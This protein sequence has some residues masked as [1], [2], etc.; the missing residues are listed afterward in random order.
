MLTGN[1]PYI[2]LVP[3]KLLS[4]WKR[5][6][7]PTL[8]VEASALFVVPLVSLWYRWEVRT[9]TMKRVAHDKGLPRYTTFTKMRQY[10][11]KWANWYQTHDNAA[12]EYWYGKYDDLVND[13]FTQE[14]YDKSWL[15]Q[16]YN[17]VRWHWRNAAY[18]FSYMVMG[19]PK[20]DD[21]PD[22]FEAGI[23][24]S[25]K[26]WVKITT[27]QNWFQYEAQLPDDEGEYRS[28]NIGWKINRSGPA[29]E[30][31]TYNVMYANRLAWLSRKEYK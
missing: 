9:D 10:L 6:F 29:L 27:H 1:L 23:E 19:M 26:T 20:G 4:K 21:E 17:R 28:V 25:G 24:D 15:L 14:D 31:G 5:R 18:T 16:Y 13:I 12:D 30:D 3:P 11:P 8:I 22:T 2:D 7:F